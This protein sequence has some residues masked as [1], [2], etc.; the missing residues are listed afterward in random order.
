MEESQ[1]LQLKG[2]LS[3][4]ILHEIGQK[5]LCGDD[6]A[7]KIGK[8]KGSKLTPGTIYP[9]LKDLRKQK[10]ISYKKFGRKK[11]YTLSQLGEKE[12]ERLYVLFSQ[13][14]FG[15]KQ[16]IKRDSSKP[17]KTKISKKKAVSKAKI[18]K[19]EESKKPLRNSRS[20]YHG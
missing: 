10:Y 17:T 18:N 7:E 19:K 16:H 20:F 11:I 6:L 5:R 1:Y 13:Y 3:F 4:L 8:R 2:F 14:F 15:L 12:L 9:A